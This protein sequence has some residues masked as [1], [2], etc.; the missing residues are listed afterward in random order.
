MEYMDCKSLAECEHFSFFE[1]K[2]HVKMLV[3]VNKNIDYKIDNAISWLYQLSDAVDY[4][5]SKEQVHR[6]L[7]CQ[8]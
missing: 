1:K 6:D 5:H 3:L 4:F 2:T 8:K 7:K